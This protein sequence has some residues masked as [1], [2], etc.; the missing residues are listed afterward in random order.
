[1]I[2]SQPKEMIGSFVNVRQG[3]PPDTSWGN[4][5]ALGL[6]RDGILVAGVIYNC[7]EGVNVNMHI[8]AV[9][10]SKWMT[11]DFLHAS[12]DYPFNQLKRRRV[13]ACINSN[14]KKAVSFVEHLG[15]EYEGRRKNYYENGDMLL[16]GM[17][18]EKCR[19]IRNIQIRKAA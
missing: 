11:A 16:Y 17:L 14:R 9:D 5:N 7:F 15:F 3:F 4:F 18:R 2:I 13:S 6:V 8:G 19:F 12:F 1:M 10:G